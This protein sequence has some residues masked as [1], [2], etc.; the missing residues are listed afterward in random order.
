MSSLVGQ[1]FNYTAAFGNVHFNDATN[2]AV[3]DPPIRKISLQSLWINSEKSHSLGRSVAAELS[4]VSLGDPRA[5]VS[6]ASRA[7]ATE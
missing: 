6:N 5:L 2:V 1:I 3:F 4:V 7:V